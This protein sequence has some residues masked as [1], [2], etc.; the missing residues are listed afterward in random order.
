MV[1]GEKG[2]KLSSYGKNYKCIFIFH[3]PKLKNFHPENKR[4]FHIWIFC[5]A[6]LNFLGLSDTIFILEGSILNAF[7]PRL[8]TLSEFSHIYWRLV[9]VCMLSGVKVIYLTVYQKLI[10]ISY[11][12]WKKRKMYWERS[13]RIFKLRKNVLHI[14]VFLQPITSLIILFCKLKIFVLSVEFPQNSKP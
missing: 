13:G 2:N 6:I 3:F 10:F 1:V 14:S 7:A 8:L 5:K 12:K 9:E 4:S 11:H